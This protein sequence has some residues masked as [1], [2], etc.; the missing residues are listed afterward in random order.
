MMGRTLEVL[1]GRLR[2]GAGGSAPASIPMRPAA[3][4]IREPDPEPG[5]GPVLVPLT[6]DDL[7][8]DRE[9]VPHIEVGGPRAKAPAGPQLV[10]PRLAPAP[11]AA[12]V[13]FQLL[14]AADPATAPVPG[15]DLIAYHRPDH[16]AA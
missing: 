15:P 6:S 9:G 11:P 3:A 8:G 13:V 10:P 7:P 16:P 5:E 12:E 4:P 2:K 1:A 14:P